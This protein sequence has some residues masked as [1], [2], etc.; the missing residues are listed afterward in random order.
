MAIKI[1]IAVL[2]L[3]P[4][5]LIQINM[6]LFKTVFSRT[7]TA[8]REQERAQ[9][10]FESLSA[11]HQSMHR[12]GQKWLEATPH[13]A[14]VIKSQDSLT[15]C[16]KLY[17]AEGATKTIILF[18]DFRTTAQTDFAPIAPFFHE[19]GLNVLLVDQRAH[20]ASEGKYICHG[21]KERYDCLEWIELVRARYGREHEIYLGGMAMGATTVLLAAGL[22]L[23]GNV[24]G[25]IAESSYTSCRDILYDGAG[26]SVWLRHI[27][28]AILPILC[29]LCRWIARFDPAKVSTV[30]AM[31]KNKTPV[32]FIHAQN[33]A[34]VPKA[35][36]M[37]AYEACTAP[38]ELYVE[39]GA[40]HGLTYLSHQKKCQ[41]LVK[42]FLGV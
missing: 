20:A 6:Y 7:K 27:H 40:G 42:R 8:A 41:Q 11:R 17:P 26:R 35:M 2:I 13:E 16:G 3:L 19:T 29:L 28:R 25:I 39:D 34:L 9:E 33:D 30:E 23:P 32:L 22:N 1:I 37:A 21:V 36:T 10:A 18:H 24:K 38:K 15:L 12:K 4:A 14:V 31:K 5:A